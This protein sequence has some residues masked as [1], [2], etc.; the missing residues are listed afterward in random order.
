MQ[1]AR[2]RKQG[3]G[4]VYGMIK[5]GY[6]RVLVASPFDGM[7]VATSE[8]CSFDE[9]EILPP[10]EPEK[11]VA[12]GLNY[13][14]HASEL[15]MEQ[16]EKPLIFLKPPSS[17]IGNNGTIILPG[18]SSKVDYEAEL[19][20]VIGKK[21]RKIPVEDADKYIF[22]YTCINDVTARDIQKEDKQ[23][24][25]SKSFD[26]F[27]PVG[28]WIE[29]ELD[30]SDLAISCSVNGE[31]RQES[32]TS[33]MIHSPQSLVSFISGVMTLEPGDIISTGTPPG[34][35]QLKSGDV[36]SIDIQGIGELVNKVK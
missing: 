1:I 27:C 18:E 17:L 31:K 11:I 10:C 7:I 24:T 9:V 16:P 20:I 19:G 26:T 30:P 29:T 14:D 2:F 25:R 36:V 6:L 13:R 5:E 32:R 15:G 35:G 28:P 3:H 21:A 12:V 34:V 8:T 4:A 33:Q 22:G 23:F